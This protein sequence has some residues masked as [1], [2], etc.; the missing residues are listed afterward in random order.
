MKNISIWQFIN[1]ILETFRE[2]FTRYKTFSWFV[3]IVI[4]QM[5]GTEAMGITG[6]IRELY[7]DPQKYECLLLFFRSDAWKLHKL[8]QK[9]QQVVSR[10]G[11]V[12]KEGDLNIL[13]GDGT[14]KMH[15]GEKMPG[16]KKM[17][18]T[19]EDNSKPPYFFGRL[20][21]TIGILIENA[22]KI[23]CTPIAIGIHDGV[24]VIR[25][26]ED[27]A[28]ENVSHV[29]QIIKDACQS[30]KDIGDSILLLDRY[31]LSV[32]ALMALAAYMPQ[33]R[34]I[35]IV[36]RAKKNATAYFKPIPPV[37]PKIGRPRK[38]GEKVKLRDY[39][40]DL[41]QFTTTTITMYGK[42]QTIKY[43]YIDLLWGSKLYR[44]LRF[45]LVCYDDTQAILTTTNLD[46]SPIKVIELYCLRQKVEVSFFSLKHVVHGLASRFWSKSMPVLNRYWKK[47][48]IDPLAFIDN[49]HEQKNII[50]A[51]KAAEGFALCGCI[52]L[53][54]LQM[55]S[56]KFHEIT[57]P[58]FIRW[59]R[60]YSS[61]VSS[62]ATI[63]VF[64]RSNLFSMLNKPLKYTIFNII[65]D[66]QMLY[67]EIL[68]DESA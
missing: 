49:P 46:F 28:Y 32:P 63:A 15:E 14:N 34:T 6:I 41:D 30:V 40:E 53:G 5:I 59:L 9:W 25:K 35:H 61:N 17:R 16:V 33:G 44:E 68:L 39:F 11:L 51:L 67:D 54:L 42:K 50:G 31:Y 29:V 8:T 21:G 27:A 62:E 12:K 47:G 18:Q 23:F 60:P 19:S 58:K 43:Y 3:I 52:A 20:Y 38:K 56:L 36:T 65:R 48:D 4:G 26:W 2:D 57:N 22:G 55:V 7:I 13:V 1:G 10:C 45:V 37:K 66:K 64:L 24:S